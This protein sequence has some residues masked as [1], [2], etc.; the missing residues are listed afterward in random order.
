MIRVKMEIGNVKRKMLPAEERVLKRFGSFGMRTARQQIRRRKKESPPGK[1]P[2]NKL[3]TLKRFTL[4]A[5]DRQTRSV[6]IGYALLPG[7]KD[8]PE[9]LEVGKDTTR[10][11]YSRRERRRMRVRARYLPRP[12]IEPAVRKRLPELPGLWKDAVR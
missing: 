10:V 1:P 4:F 7:K 12:N 8:A 2:R 9:A 3:G 5:Y 11:V 6:V